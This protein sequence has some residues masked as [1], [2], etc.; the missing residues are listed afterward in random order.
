MAGRGEGARTTGVRTRWAL[1]AR[2]N[3]EW[4]WRHLIE[5]DYIVGALSVR[6]LHF[7]TERGWQRVDEPAWS[8]I[9]A[10]ADAYGRVE[11]VAAGEDQLTVIL[12]G[13][14]GFYALDVLKSDH[15]A[16]MLMNPEGS[17]DRFV[18][19]GGERFSEDQVV[20]D[21]EVVVEVIRHLVET[22]EYVDH[23]VAKWEHRTF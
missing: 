18:E 16:A 22:G 13:R 21:I 1:A 7:E 11:L 10:V 2:E 6:A 23:D 8:D 5:V 3:F 17:A 15:G 19:I 9:E 4:D 20:S 12:E 14:P